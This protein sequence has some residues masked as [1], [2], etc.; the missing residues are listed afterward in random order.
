MLQKPILRAIQILNLYNTAIFFLENFIRYKLQI[1]EI[2]IGLFKNGV[3]GL[4]KGFN[5]VSRRGHFGHFGAIITTSKFQIE[6]LLC[7]LKF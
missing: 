5:I 7:T 2:C 6:G 3:R 1:I 4:I